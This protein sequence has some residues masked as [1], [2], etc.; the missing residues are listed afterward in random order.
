MNLVDAKHDVNF[1]APNDKQFNPFIAYANGRDIFD[2]LRTWELKLEKGKLTLSNEVGA[3]YDIGEVGETVQRLSLAFFQFKQ[4][5]LV[6]E[7]MD[8]VKIS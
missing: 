6:L 3:N 7:F 5:Y 1:K 2:E 8:E 4:P